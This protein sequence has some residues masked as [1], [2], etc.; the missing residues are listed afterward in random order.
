MR[1]TLILFAHGSRD[2]EWSRPF[3]ELAERV[4][5]RASGSDVRLAYLELMQPRLPEAAAAAIEAGTTSIRIVPIF[6]AQGAHVRTDLAALITQLRAR[7]P[8]VKIECSEPAG[9]NSAVLDAVA[10]YCAQELEGK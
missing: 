8:T 3:E 10:V 9:E 4:R 5:R 1:S 6:L 7:H 2:P